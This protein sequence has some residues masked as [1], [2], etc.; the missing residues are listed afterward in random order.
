M[1]AALREFHSSKLRVAHSF[2]LWERLDFYEKLWEGEPS[3]YADYDKTKRAV[4]SLK[5]FIDE[6]PKRIQLCH[7]DAVPDNFLFVHDANGDEQIKLIDWEY[8]GMQDPHLDVAM[9]IIYAMYDQEAAEKLIDLYF[10][11]G[12]DELTRMKLHCY[13][14]VSGLVWSNWCEFKHHCGVEFG[15][16]MTTQENTARYSSENTERYLAEIM[17]EHMIERAIIMAAGIGQRLRPV[18]LTTPKPLVAVNGVRMID[19]I[20]A[21]LHKNGIYEIYVVVGYLK[22]QFYEWAKKYDGITLIENPWYAECN[23]I[24]SLYVAREYLNNVIILDGDQIIRNPAIFHR[25]FT[26]SGYSCAWTDSATSEW[27][28]TVENGIVTKC[29]RTGGDHGWQFFSVSRWT[30]EDGQRLRNHL[31]LE[32]VQNQNRSIYWDDVAMFCHPDEY[33]LGVYPISKED[34]R[35]IDS[36][37]ELCEADPSY[38]GGFN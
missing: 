16:N 15:V 20:I 11:D 5:R 3:I 27:L 34:L 18:T 14:A 30:A 37:A 2:D 33:Q 23:N 9:F 24:A 22:E 8:A 25:E 6:Q 7:I 12:C 32:F 19:T 31:E 1:S 4:L 26:R 28:L 13:I 10:I 29:S 35:E 21:A 38:K 17:S 36:F